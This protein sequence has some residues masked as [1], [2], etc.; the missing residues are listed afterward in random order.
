MPSV[1]PLRI[2]RMSDIHGRLR[3]QAL[4]AMRDR[5]VVVHAGDI[6]NPVILDALPTR[7]WVQ[8]SAATS[9]P[10]HGRALP[11]T[12]VVGIAGTHP[13]A[14][15]G[16]RD[17]SGWPPHRSGHPSGAAMRRCTPHHGGTGT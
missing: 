11:D 5:V 10:R 9:M 2:G 14:L 1:S 15:R 13:H 6:G 8:R 16:V 7:A 12:L 17:G 4:A 3:P